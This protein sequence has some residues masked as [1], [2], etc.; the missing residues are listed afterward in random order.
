[1]R[2]IRITRHARNRMR[3][4]KIAE[5]VILEAAGDPDRGASDIQPRLAP[6]RIGGSVVFITRALPNLEIRADGTA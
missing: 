1:M 2:S 5:D 6:R 3:W 4:R